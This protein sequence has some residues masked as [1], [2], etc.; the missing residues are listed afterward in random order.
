MDIFIFINFAFKIIHSPFQTIKRLYISFLSH[1][2]RKAFL[3]LSENKKINAGERLKINSKNVFP[4]VI[5]FSIVGNATVFVADEIIY[6]M[7]S[8]NISAFIFKLVYSLIISYI[9]EFVI[10]A[11]ILFIV[12]LSK[13]QVD[14]RA[15]L[16]LFLFTDGFKVVMLPISI[17]ISAF[18][19]DYISLYELIAFIV[20]ILILIFKVYAVKLSAK[21]S[22]FLAF[23]GYILPLLVIIFTTFL[24]FIYFFVSIVSHSV[25]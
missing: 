19:I 18:N 12:M 13:R 1:F 10:L 11:S 20:A 17:I 24:F 4:F 2:D 5:L 23:L 14:F 21:V 22:E 8:M 25:I 6:R 15:L 9:F 3:S 7:G 16:A